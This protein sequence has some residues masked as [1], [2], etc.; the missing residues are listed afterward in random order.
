[1]TRDAWLQAL[2]ILAVFFALEVLLPG[3]IVCNVFEAKEQARRCKD[4]HFAFI[5]DSGNVSSDTVCEV[6][7]HAEEIS[8]RD[9]VYLTLCCQSKAKGKDEKEFRK[10]M[11]MKARAARCTWFGSRSSRAGEEV[12]D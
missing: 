6:C 12:A 8:V 5:S 10:C 7:R 1:M 9:N 3:K 4:L 11:E 2:V